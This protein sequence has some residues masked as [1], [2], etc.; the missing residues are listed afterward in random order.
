MD[1]C[2]VGKFWN[3]NAEAWTKLSRMGYD[4]CR[5]VVNTPAFLKMLPNVNGLNGL[6]IGCGEGN[7]TRLVAKLGAKM[8]A[9]D[10]A[11]IFVAHAEEKEKE[12][13]LG[14]DYLHASAVDLPFSNDAFDFA[15]ATMSFMDMPD[16]PRVVEEAFRVIKPGG[17]LQF[18]ISHPC[19]F[20]PQR[21]VIRNEAGKEIAISVWDYFRSTDGEIEEWTFG[22]AP[23]SIKQGLKKF[24]VPRFHRTLSSWLN[25]LCNAGFRPEQFDEPFP[26]EETAR[27]CPYVADMRFT[28]HFLIIRCSKPAL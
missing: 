9:I 14:I 7:N 11:E 13:P 27:R 16:H 12:E 17:F 21:S 6:D 18:S 3:E 15:M 5:D 8:T 2:E 28:A 22:A 26:D 1:H 4:L 20:P 23:D 19:F 24:Q 25:L 10:I